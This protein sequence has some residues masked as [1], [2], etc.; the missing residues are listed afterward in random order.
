M[1]SDRGVPVQ[2]MNFCGDPTADF[3]TAG[4]Y[5]R[6]WYEANCPELNLGGW[7]AALRRGI[8]RVL[9]GYR[10]YD[11]DRDRHNLMLGLIS[12]VARI[13]AERERQKKARY[14][15]VYYAL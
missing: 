5:L 15:R 7:R 2:E 12:E 4:V 8:R 11:L 9:F 6:Q 3:D 13:D 1:P 14:E 10:D